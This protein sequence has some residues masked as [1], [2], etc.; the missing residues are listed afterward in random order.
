[1]VHWIIPFA[2]LAAFPAAVAGQS[3][4]DF[5]GDWVRADSAAE[6]RT[7]G[8]VGDAGFRVGTMGGGWG[9][10]MTL[11][12]ETGQLV[13]E[14]A[15][16]GSYDLQPRLRLS[17]ALDGSE[18]L[19]PIMI[20]HAESMLRSRAAWRGDT[21]VITTLHPAPAGANATEVRQSLTLASPTSL[22]VETSRPAGS[23]AAPTVTRSTY[24]RR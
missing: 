20:G 7:V 23:G 22:V 19:N 4:P 2:L 5:S 11:R 9:S 3:R 14:Y 12:Q 10:P 8:T 18:S 21:L 15:F 17:V 6:Q 1:M 24:S 13:V 16:F